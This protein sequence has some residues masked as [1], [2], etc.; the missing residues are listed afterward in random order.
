MVSATGL[1]G[2]AMMR[3]RLMALVVTLGCASA[4]GAGGPNGAA[5]PPAPATARAPLFERLGGKPAI[6][7]VVDDL[8]GRAA[9]DTRINAKLANADLAHLRAA[10]I[11][12]I[13]E[14]AGGPCKYAGKDMKVAHAGMGI[15]GAEFDAL[16]EDLSAT[17]EQFKVPAQE[18]A[19]LIGLLAPTKPDIVAGAPPP[20]GPPSVAAAPPAPGPGAV[21][22][23]AQGLR[24]AAALLEKADG[25]RRQGSRSL[26][27]QLFSF[28]ELIVG[29]DA[30][31]PLAPM[32]REGAPPRITTPLLPVRPDAAAQPRAVGS[33]DDEQNEP[34]APPPARGSLEGT[35]KVPGAASVEGLAVVTLEPASG[36]FHHRSPRNRVME[37]RNREFGPH[38][39]VVPTGSTVS[40]PN[41]DP[42]Y[43]NVFSRSEGKPFDLGVYKAGQAREVLFD[44]EGIVRVGC[45]LH[46]NM[47]AYIVVVSAPHYTITDAR[48]SF[49]FRNLEP[50]KYRLRVY[51]ERGERPAVQE[52]T[53][54]AARNT[55]AVE[56]PGGGPLGPLADKFGAPRAPKSPR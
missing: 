55:V 7:A 3:I 43:H 51:S 2:K 29:P 18:R 56:L 5:T 40:F 31:A 42:V 45:N 41:F 9:K 8:L 53:V 48:G 25:A 34:P 54:R 26:A 28:A 4:G 39:L 47:S 38:V 13:C 50:G 6:T 17:L 21:V 52:V 49:A 16:V 19:E 15:T 37:Q 1:L 46:A 33:S 20:P 27:E 12:Q 30:L 11:D 23:R 10:L 22:E 32:F 44:R 36:R 35:L 24:E 14:L